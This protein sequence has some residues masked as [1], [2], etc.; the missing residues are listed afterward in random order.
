MGSEQ[1]T[2][3]IQ[4]KSFL[5]WGAAGTKS[6]DGRVSDAQKMYQGQKWP[7]QSQGWGAGHGGRNM[8]GGHQRQLESM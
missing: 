4:E 7:G 3:A 1:A 8:V 5:G 6:Q 2:V